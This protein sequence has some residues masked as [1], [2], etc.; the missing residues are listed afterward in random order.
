[1]HSERR[2]PEED[3]HRRPEAFRSGEGVLAVWNDCNTPSKPGVPPK[4]LN[5]AP[6]PVVSPYANI[7]EQCLE[8]YG[9]GSVLSCLVYVAR[10]LRIPA[11]L[12][13][14]LACGTPT[15]PPQQA[16]VRMACF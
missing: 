9:F 7:Y 12:H 4:L 15:G 13:P 1:M 14:I 2:Q 11:H 6:A 3:H 5:V 10:C 16:K 8:T